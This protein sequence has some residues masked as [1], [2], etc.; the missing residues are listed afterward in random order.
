MAKLKEILGESFSQIPENLKTKY[1][2]IDL[3]D[4]VEY[5][6][7]SD[8]DELEKTA[9]QYKTEIKKRDDDLKDLGAKAKDNEE[10]NKE[11]LRLQGENQ[12][13]NEDHEAALKQIR[14]DAALEKKLGDFKPKNLEILKKAL[15]MEKISLDGENLLGLDEQITKLKESDSYLFGD[16]PPQGGTGSLGGGSSLADDKKGQLSLGAR[17]AEQRK[18]ANQVTE[19]QN[20]FFN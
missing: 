20:K 2:N 10:L 7:K 16:E 1:E 9:K 17:L 14:F 4:S 6:K 15:E 8:Y 12:K 5:V 11:I 19:V 18:N 3:V 13:A